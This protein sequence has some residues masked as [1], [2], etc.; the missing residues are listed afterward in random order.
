MLC[1]LPCRKILPI[2]GEWK[3]DVAVGITCITAAI[4]ASTKVHQNKVQKLFIYV[5]SVV[6]LRPG[7]QNVWYRIASLTERPFLRLYRRYHYVADTKIKKGDVNLVAPNVCFSCLKNQTIIREGGRITAAALREG[8]STE[9]RG[10][11]ANGLVL[12]ADRTSAHLPK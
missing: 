4:Q 10:S 1:M 6:H 12:V 7:N 8:L 2:D 9:D 5:H 11:N 3:V